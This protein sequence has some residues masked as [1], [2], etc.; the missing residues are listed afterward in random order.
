MKDAFFC[1]YI[2]I[3]AKEGFFMLP[4]RRYFL[5]LMKQIPSLSNVQLLKMLQYL[6][7]YHCKQVSFLEL[8]DALQLRTKMKEVLI[9]SYEKIL[10]N[11]KKWQLNYQNEKFITLL[12]EAYPSCLAEIYNPPVLLF[13]RGDIQL[14]SKSS[15]ALIGSRAATSSGRKVIER[16]VPGLVRAGIPIVSGLARGIDTYAHQM[17]IRQKGSTIAVI[18]SG[19]ERT[20]PKENFRLQQFIAKNHLLVTEYP[21]DTPPFSYHFPMRN[22]IIAGITQGTC[23]VEAR[24]RSG[25]LIT[26]QY[27]LEAG[28]S[29]FCVPGDSTKPTTEGCHELIQQGAKCIWKSE[30]IIE[31]FL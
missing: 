9:T 3:N 29:V 26:A 20:Y 23:V 4:E 19:L 2:D 28:R 8:C 11:E 17:T 14:L 1:K 13:Y 25:T 22:R 12:D 18:G 24:R 5:F 30:H 15:L 27:A 7:N 16:L 6:E 31:E 21:D 10:K